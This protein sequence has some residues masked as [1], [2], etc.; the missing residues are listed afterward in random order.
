MAEV[1]GGSGVDVDTIVAQATAEGMGAIAVV[2]L[3]GPESTAILERLSPP[4]A[5][6][7]GPRVARLTEIVEP[8]DGTVIDRALVT[9]FEAPASYTGEDMVEISCHGGWLTPGL[10]VEACLRAGARAAEPGEFTKRAYLRGKLDM[11][12]SE[13]VADLIEARSTAMRDAALG[14]LE[15]GLSRRISALRER[16]V[17]VE[18]LLAHHVDFPEE[19]DAPVPLDEIAAEARGLRSDLERM[20]ATAPEGELLRE[21]ALAVF[22]GAP[23]V[24][25]SSLYNAL[26]GEER[27]IV[28][29]EAGTTRDAL[30]APVQLGGYPFRLVDTAGLREE[31]AHVERLGIEVARSYLA[32]ADVI[33]LCI[34]GWDRGASLG[35]VLDFLGRDGEAPV[36]LVET[37]ADLRRGEAALPR[38]KRGKSVGDL[39]GT[40]EDSQGG[41]DAEAPPGVV[42]RVSVSVETGEGLDELRLLLPELIYSAT[43]RSGSESPVLLRRRHA[44]AVATARD[45]VDAFLDALE[46]GVPAE[47]AASHLQG[48]GT[49]LEELLGVISVDDVL[50]VVFRDFCIGK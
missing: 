33:L 4:G 41:A 3:S 35:G 30:E 21:G 40:L 24:G 27:A 15:R 13:A 32:R 5:G 16:L 23:N 17:Q 31:A 25:K 49:A 45:E 11:V 50:D 8:G 39:P 37:K 48:A 43:I 29:S 38:G 20:L 22:A 36:V 12:Q 46:G 26:V 44:R 6:L 28:T 2:R 10:V 1:G 42:G 19:D 47:M 18:A 34:E 14:Q 7:P 9:R